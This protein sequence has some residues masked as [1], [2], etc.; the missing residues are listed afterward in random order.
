MRA[1]CPTMV[2]EIAA[3]TSCK[4]FTQID[5]QIL[6]SCRMLYWSRRARQMERPM[7]D[8][9]SSDELIDLG[10]ASEVTLGDPGPDQEDLDFQTEEVA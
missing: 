4:I 6:P 5:R 8:E 9:Q 3:E 2:T 10:A 1:P 7:R